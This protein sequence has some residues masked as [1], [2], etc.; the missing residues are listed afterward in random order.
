MDARVVYVKRDKWL[1][2]WSF[3]GNKIMKETNKINEDKAYEDIPHLAYCM[4]K[5]RLANV[6][7]IL[8]DKID[9]DLDLRNW[10][11]KPINSM[12]LSDDRIRH[13]SG[14]PPR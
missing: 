5:W 9:N 13:A 2:L 8:G 1:C 7:T 11:R 3:L 12:K 10:K 14:P 6:M 4:G